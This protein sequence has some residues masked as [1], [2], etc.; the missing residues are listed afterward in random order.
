MVARTE[1]GGKIVAIKGYEFLLFDSDA[2]ALIDTPEKLKTGEGITRGVFTGATIQLT[3]L[4]SPT[5][6][7]DIYARLADRIPNRLQ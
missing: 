7:S 4:E 2:D 3:P 6:A 5:L 1:G